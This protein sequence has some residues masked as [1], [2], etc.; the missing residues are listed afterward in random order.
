MYFRKRQAR[1]AASEQLCPGQGRR[2]VS[3]K[4]LHEMP[5][6]L[7]RTRILDNVVVSGLSAKVMSQARHT[8]KMLFW[9]VSGL[10][11]TPGRVPAIPCSA[12]FKSSLALSMLPI[13][14]DSV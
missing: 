3:P 8:Q 10:A 2:G 4:P 13:L 1:L 9:K 5:G 6:E 14:C 11:T 7:P 12:Q